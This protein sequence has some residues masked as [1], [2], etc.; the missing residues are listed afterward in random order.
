MTIYRSQVSD[1]SMSPAHESEY[2]KP[3]MEH[4]PIYTAMNKDYIRI[5]KDNSIREAIEK[6]R[7]SRTKG[8]V[9][10][11]NGKLEGYISIENIPQD[12]NYDETVETVMLQDVPIISSNKSLHDALNMIVNE[13][14]GKLVVVDNNEMDKILGTLTLSEISEAYNRE[15]RR[16]KERTRPLKSRAI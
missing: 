11:N 5:G 2:R 16:I 14:T 12:V 6:I 3:I 10:E 7:S 1:R 15:I 8:I 13:S 4:I 9:V